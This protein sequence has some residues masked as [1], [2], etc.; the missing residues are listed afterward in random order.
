MLKFEE[1]SVAKRLRTLYEDHSVSHRK[2]PRSASDGLKN[3]ERAHFPG[4]TDE[5]CGSVGLQVL[6]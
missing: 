2:I 1:K 5:K 4:R 3:K 6:T